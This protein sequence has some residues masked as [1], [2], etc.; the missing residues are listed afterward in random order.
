MLLVAREEG[1]RVTIIDLPLSRLL[2][3]CLAL[4]MAFIIGAIFCLRLDW[5]VKL[6]SVTL[7]SV[8]GAWLWRRYL[9]RRPARLQVGIDGEICLFRADG[10]Q[11]AVTAVL[12]GIISPA[13]VSARLSGHTGQFAD[14]FVPASS[15]DEDSHWHLRRAL[16]RFQ[17]PEAGDRRGT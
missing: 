2:K 10:G 17:P 14:L 1:V 5:A 7:V 16:I 15:L 4:L 9:A 11:F 6:A 13:L 12:P 8:W 3:A